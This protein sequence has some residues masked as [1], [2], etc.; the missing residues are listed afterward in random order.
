M[1]HRESTLTWIAILVATLALGLAS[2]SDALAADVTTVVILD[3]AES[4]GSLAWFVG[5]LD[6]YATRFPTEGMQ[7][8]TVFGLLIAQPTPGGDGTFLPVEFETDRILGTFGELSGAINGMTTGS[9]ISS[10]DGF[11]GITKALETWEPGDVGMNLIMLTGGARAVWSEGS[12][13]DADAVADAVWGVPSAFVNVIIDHGFGIPGGA[14]GPGPTLGAYDWSTY[15]A[16]PGGTLGQEFQGWMKIPDSGLGE[17]YADLVLDNALGSAWD[18]EQAEVPESSS[19]FRRGFTNVKI[20]EFGG[21]A[22]PPVP[23]PGTAA[24]LGLGVGVIALVIRRR[25]SRLDRG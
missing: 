2:T 13:L 21:A 6:E 23:E 14:P 24:L 7:H 10:V 22:A 11:L 25:R 16:L 17:A 3:G 19:A 4:G 12:T 15:H 1:R 8:D 18:L 9:G 5:L 20:E